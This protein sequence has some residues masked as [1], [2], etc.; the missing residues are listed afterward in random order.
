MVAPGYALAPRP[1]L[2]GRYAMSQQKRWPKECAE[3]IRRAAPAVIVAGSDAAADE[4][5]GFD[6]DGIE[7]AVYT[8]GREGTLKISREPGGGGGLRVES[9]RNGWH[10]N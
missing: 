6:F 10:R 1:K 9:Y 5:S 8:P 2:V 4:L 7:A 3:L